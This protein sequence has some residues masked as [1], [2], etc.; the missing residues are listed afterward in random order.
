[1]IKIRGKVD[2][3][4]TYNSVSSF[5]GLEAQFKMMP[6]LQESFIITSEIKSTAFTLVLAGRLQWSQRDNE[7]SQY[8]N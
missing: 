3:S 1:M 5:S 4:N 6:K 7:F 2:K 8:F